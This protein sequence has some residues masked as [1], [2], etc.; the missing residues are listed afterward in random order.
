MDK[1]LVDDVREHIK[2]NQDYALYNGLLY[3]VAYQYD[4]I[5]EEYTDFK[6]VDLTLEDIISISDDIMGG[7][8]M[9]EGLIEMIQSRLYDYVDNKGG[10]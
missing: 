5:K 3:E 9:N 10:K 6:D 7:Y 8:Y 4:W 1:Y 2:N